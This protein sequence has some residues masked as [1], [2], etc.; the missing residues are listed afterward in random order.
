[1]STESVWSL[2]RGENFLPLPGIEPRFR[3]S[4]GRSLVTIPT[5]LYW[6]QIGTVRYRL[7]SV[8]STL[9][10]IGDIE[11]AIRTGAHSI[12]HTSSLHQGHKLSS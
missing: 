10:L 5:M 2:W 11:N 6:F 1:V 9:G 7:K 3:G 8:V 4:P 12:L